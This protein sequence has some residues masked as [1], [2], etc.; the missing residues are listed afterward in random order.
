MVKVFREQGSGYEYRDRQLLTELRRMVRNREIDCIIIYAID[1]LSRNQIHMAVL[2]D[3]FTHHGVEVLCVRE[4]FDDSP[5]GKFML[6]AMSFVAEVQRQKTLELTDQGRR[7]RISEGKIM[8]GWKPRYGYVWIGD[9]KERFGLNIVEAEV[10]RR[11]FHL[12]VYDRLTLKRIAKLLT[13]EGIPSPAGKPCWYDSTI[14]RILQ[15]PIYIGIGSAF[16]Y[17]SHSDKPNVKY[18]AKL[19][20]QEEWLLLP[21]GVVPAIV[22]EVLFK[23]AGERLRLNQL[24]ASRN[25]PNPESTLL[26][27]GFIK[28]G[29]C[30][31]AMQ[32]G[33][34]GGPRHKD[35]TLPHEYRCVWRNKGI[36]PCS[37]APVISINRIDKAVWEYIGEIVK[38]FSLVEEAIKLIKKEYPNQ[39]DLKSIEH[40]I[41]LAKASQEQLVQDLK[42]VEQDGSLK[43]KGRARELV[44]DELVKSEKSLEK[45]EAERQKVLAGKSDW[46]KMQEDIDKFLEWCLNAKENYPK[47]TYDDKRRA[48]RNLGIVV[49]VYREDDEEHKR[50]EITV[51]MPDIVRHTS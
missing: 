20:S 46:Q 26:R 12:Y 27:C 34:N 23:Q 10:V 30:K 35:P 13:D 18:S 49:Y 24:E 8:P 3:E 44:I 32:A 38:D 48:L 17:T 40:S 7:K 9:K 50:Y 42:R 2:I 29:Y 5:Q 47:A 43:L 22:D 6:S 31:R 1:R 16:K 39:P 33:R 14:R 45:L 21:D 19:K 41:K 37:Q 11:I 51:R 36:R 28:C 25:N 4:K 15:D